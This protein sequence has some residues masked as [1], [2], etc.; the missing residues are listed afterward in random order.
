MLIDSWEN[1]AQQAPKPPK[2]TPKAKAE[3]VDN[4]LAEHS[5]ISAKDITAARRARNS[6]THASDKITRET[7]DHALKIINKVNERLNQNS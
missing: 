4:W 1:L 6:A 3:Y 2:S 5:G 7:M